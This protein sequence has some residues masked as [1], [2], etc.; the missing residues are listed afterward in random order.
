MPVS[1]ADLLATVGS[2][3]SPDASERARAADE[4]TDFAK[5]LKADHAEV[6]ARLLVVLRLGESD[7]E[8]QEAQL[9][10]LSELKEWYEIKNATLLRLRVVPEDSLRGSQKEHFDDILGDLAGS[11]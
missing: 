5:S 3:L 6:L 1:D 10:A 9:N 4:I 11:S 8:C 2:L 7:V